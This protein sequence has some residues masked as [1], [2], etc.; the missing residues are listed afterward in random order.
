LSVSYQFITPTFKTIKMKFSSL[1]NT[2]LLFAVLLFAFSGL[3]AQLLGKDK[4]KDSRNNNSTA[5]TQGRGGPAVNQTYFIYAKHS[6]LVMDVAGGGTAN[7]TGI[8][9]YAKHGGVNQQWKL[10]SGANG[11]YIIQSVGSGKVIDVDACRKEDGTKVQIWDKHGGGNQQFTFTP[12]SGGYFKITNVCTGKVLDFQGGPAATQSGQKLHSWKW[13][14]AA[15]EYF[16]LVPVGNTPAPSRNNLVYGKTYHLQNGYANWGGGYL[17]VCGHA[18]YPYNK[19]NVSCTPSKNRSSNS[20][21]WKILSAQGKSNGTVVMDGDKVRLL[22]MY[23]GGKGGY[24]DVCGKVQCNKELYDCSTSPSGDRDGVHT[25][26]WTIATLVAGPIE[27]NE[28]VQFRSEYNR[29]WWLQ[30]CGHDKCS[31]N[32]SYDV[33]VWDARNRV[34]NVTHWKMSPTN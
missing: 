20:G 28:M 13:W 29:A 31:G 17:D 33:N 5:T 10:L 22:N 8:I 12:L 34:Q 3:E 18:S 2:F 7:G 30:T 25:S 21:S 19:Y 26:T 32:T 1:K 11:S 6:G 15:N 23:D 9:Q 16:K 14:D 27:V 24:L 4:I